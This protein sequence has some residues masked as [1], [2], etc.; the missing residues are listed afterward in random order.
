[1]R[2]R[3]AVAGWRRVLDILDIAPDVSD[4]GPDGRDLPREPL[5]IRF[6]GVGFQYPLSGET[7]Q[8]ASGTVAI[9]DVN[10]VIEP[11]RH[12]AVV[13][14]TGSGKTTFAKLLTRLM[15]PT[16]GEVSLGGVNISEIRFRSL[17]DRVVMVPQEGVLF[18]GSIADNVAMGK[19]EAT[20]KQIEDVFI[21]MGLEDWLVELYAGV[22]TQ[23]GRARLVALGG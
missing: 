3:P 5:Q 1:M 10:L 22:D 21:R 12:I 4:P 6:D 15:D 2:P 20:R 14:E 18:R 13:G 8:E 16:S 17:R 23:V 9:E 19:P 11:R 7:A